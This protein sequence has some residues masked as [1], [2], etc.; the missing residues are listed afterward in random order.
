MGRRK[1]GNPVNGWIN[2]NKPYDLGSTKAVSIVRRA[3]NAQKAGH[4]G[5]LDPLATGILPIALGEATK[6]IPY[7]QDD[8]K[9]YGFT[10][11]WGQSRTTDDLEGDIIHQS[12]NRPALPDIEAL[13]PEF[14]GDIQQTPPRFSAIKIDGER[15][16]DLARDGE[17]VELKSRSVY[18]ESL[19]ITDHTED[20]TTFLCRC[21]KG[22]YIRSIARDMGEKLGCYGY[23][24]KLERRAVG[25]FTLDNAISLDFLEN[26]EDSAKLEKW[27]MPLQEPLDDI[28]AFP[29]NDKEAACLR[30]G[31]SVQLVSRPD[32]SRLE[33]AGL[34]GQKETTALALSNDKAVALV[35]I[36][37]PTL[38]PVRVFNL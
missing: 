23:I 34:K 10:A 29:V 9:T 35:E 18:I 11:Q 14:T 17:A 6:I 28:P 12:D 38:K 20:T 25:A 13:L 32:F 2:L 1:K 26:I 5:T 15:A 37:G 27:V 30:N 36:T 22:T 21:G 24:S 8:L 7:I 16:Y 4:A 33:K 31:Q 19:E 3:L